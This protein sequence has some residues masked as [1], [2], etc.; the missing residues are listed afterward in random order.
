[1]FR[2]LTRLAVAGTI[3]GAGLVTLAGVADAHDFKPSVTKGTCS[4]ING[5]PTKTITV[6]VANQF[7]M[8]A[9]FT[10]AYLSAS[11]ID[12][13]ANGSNHYAIHAGGSR[14]GPDGSDTVEVTWDDGYRLQHRVALDWGSAPCAGVP[15]TTT[16]VPPTTIGGCPPGQYYSPIPPVGCYEVATTLPTEPAVTAPPEETTAATEAPTTVPGCPPGQ[17]LLTFEDGSTKCDD[18][19]YYAVVKP[20]N[21]APQVPTKLP[22]TGSSDVVPLVAIGAGIV[23]AGALLLTVRR[24]PARGC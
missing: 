20:A 8:H 7:D 12:L 11:Q 6:T 21:P 13:P 3:A 22:A 24:R 18:G 19:S 5:L 9:V 4:I 23:A 15:A 1:M 10:S 16:T 14:V 2:T 17:T